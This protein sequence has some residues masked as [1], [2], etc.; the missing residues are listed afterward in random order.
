M[1]LG[2]PVQGWRPGARRGGVYY[3]GDVA[4]MQDALIVLGATELVE[5]RALG[6]E[7]MLLVNLDHPGV[8][9]LLSLA[10]APGKNRPVYAYEYVEGAGLGAALR[11]ASDGGG[12]LPLGVAASAVAQA[13]AAAHAVCSVGA[14][15]GGHGIWHRGPTPDDV[16]M[17]STGLVRAVGF[18]VWREDARPEGVAGF[19][20]PEGQ[21]GSAGMAYGLGALLMVLLGGGTPAVA[22]GRSLQSLGRAVDEQAQSVRRLRG[23]GADP[24]VDLAQ[25]CLSWN[26][27]QRPP[28]GVL[29]ARLEELRLRAPPPGPVLWSAQAVPKLRVGKPLPVE[30]VCPRWTPRPDPLPEPEID[31]S[32]TLG[33]SDHGDRPTELLGARTVGMFSLGPPSAAEAPVLDEASGE[34]SDHGVSRW[35]K[36]ARREDGAGDT[37]VRPVPESADVAA[38]LGEAVSGPPPVPASPEPARDPISTGPETHPD[39]ITSRTAVGLGAPGSSMPLSTRVWIVVTSALTVAVIVSLVLR[40]TGL[41]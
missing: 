40:F 32:A 35:A 22:T 5:A 25:A 27:G 24:L 10:V 21:L 26:P 17:D 14:E 3:D 29:A 37:I 39:T 8:L 16:L 12:H 19:M 33:G 30:L 23:P 41:F 6:L 38:T 2:P 1:K 31:A 4:S 15:M 7:K 18:Q 28:L 9:P 13:A 36:E 20:C 34:F 11:A